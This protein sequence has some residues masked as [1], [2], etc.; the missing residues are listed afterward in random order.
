MCHGWWFTLVLFWKMILFSQIWWYYDGNDVSGSN[1]SLRFETW[2]QIKICD[3]LQITNGY[4]LWGM[5]WIHDKHLS[6]RGCESMVYCGILYHCIYWGLIMKY[7]MEHIFR[8]NNR[9]IS[10]DDPWFLKINYSQIGIEH[11]EQKYNDKIMNERERKYMSW[12]TPFWN[13]I[14]YGWQF[15]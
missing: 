3:T 15:S 9:C 8:R 1:E 7:N 14:S 10:E 2:R 4:V 11:Q 5:V 6:R 13:M 12:V